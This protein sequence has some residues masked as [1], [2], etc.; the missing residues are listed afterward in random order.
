MVIRLKGE[1]ADAAFVNVHT[2]EKAQS[3][4]SLYGEAG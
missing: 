3:R 2:S 4:R 1:V